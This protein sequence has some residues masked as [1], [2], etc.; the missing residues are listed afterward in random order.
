[1]TFTPKQ[2]QLLQQV[3]LDAVYRSEEH[4][5][6]L[7]PQTRITPLFD[8]DDSV[9]N[10]VAQEEEKLLTLKALHAAVTGAA[11]KLVTQGHS[12]SSRPNYALLFEELRQ[13]GLDS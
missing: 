11:K 12:G 3:L 6:G 9:A 10:L 1:M 5:D 8:D 7:R 2:L 13:V 4:L